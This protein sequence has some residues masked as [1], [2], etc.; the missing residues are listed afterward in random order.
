MISN[1]NDISSFLEVLEKSRA[2]RGTRKSTLYPLIEIPPC[3]RSCPFDY[4]GIFDF[5]IDLGLFREREGIVMLTNHGMSLI[6]MEHPG[7]DLTDEQTQYIVQNCIFNNKKFS[8]MTSLLRQFVFSEKVGSFII[9]DEK[10]ERHQNAVG[11]LLQFNVIQKQ[12]R[13]WIVNPDYLEH[14]EQIGKGFTKTMT[15]KQLDEIIAEQKRIGNQ[16]EELT[17]KYE[18]KQLKAKKLIFESKHVKRISNKY[19]NKGYDVES[20]SRKGKEANLFIEVKGRKYNTS[21]F[22]MSINEIKT[23]EMLGDRYAIYFWNCLGSSSEP[24]EPLKIIR[25]PFKKLSFD[26]C[27]NCLNFLIKI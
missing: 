6:A 19:V 22:I 27:E 10:T 15:Q 3:R 26:K 21:S 12:N 24:K 5:C 11:I 4:D 16:A 7:L 8:D 14:V 9:L 1:I 23:A 18:I 2:K 20:F 25:N 17:V 13:L